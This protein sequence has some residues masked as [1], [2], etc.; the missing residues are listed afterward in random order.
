MYILPVLYSTK[1]NVNDKANVTE[2]VIAITSVAVSSN[3]VNVSNF[4]TDGYYHYANSN[5]V[6]KQS[7]DSIRC[8]GVGGTYTVLG[9]LN[10]K[11]VVYVA[12]RKAN[13]IFYDSST[14]IPTQTWIG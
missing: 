3:S 1:V 6:F 14:T 2:T 13:T 10:N 9:L 8:Y 4:S 12:D 5:S 7:T 11:E